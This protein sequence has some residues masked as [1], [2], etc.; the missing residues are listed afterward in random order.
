MFHFKQIKQN[1]YSKI[2]LK[3]YPNHEQIY[4]TLCSLIIYTLCLKTWK[5]KWQPIPG[6][7]PRESNG[8]RNLVGYSHGIARVRHDLTLPFFLLSQSVK[9]LATGTEKRNSKEFKGMWVNTSSLGVV[10]GER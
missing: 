5:R 7:L 9:F 1:E 2:M 8:Q 10:I 6:F 4:I 3:K